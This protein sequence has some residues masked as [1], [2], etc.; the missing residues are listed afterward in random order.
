MNGVTFDFWQ[1]IET[2]LTRFLLVL[3]IKS[4]PINASTHDISLSF[5]PVYSNLALWKNQYD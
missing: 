1:L 3:H 2:L 5:D 4:V